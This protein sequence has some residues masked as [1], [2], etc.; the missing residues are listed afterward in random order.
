MPRDCA[1]KA[2]EGNAYRSS[3]AGYNLPP[4]YIHSFFLSKWPVGC[5]CGAITIAIAVDISGVA[6]Y[7]Y[8]HHQT[9]RCQTPSSR[10]Y[11][12]TL[13]LYHHLP[14]TLAL[15]I[16]SASPATLTDAKEFSMH[17]LLQRQIDRSANRILLAAR[18]SSARRIYHSC[19]APSRRPPHF[20]TAP[21][22][23]TIPAIP[24]ELTINA[25]M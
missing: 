20:L 3:I 17:Q 14:T 18:C 2:E 1:V 23:N 25:A 21:D 12:N 15:H 10:Q 16:D 24:Y 4:L 5:G 19:R 13:I 9:H 11:L 7:S 6:D 8:H 22:Y